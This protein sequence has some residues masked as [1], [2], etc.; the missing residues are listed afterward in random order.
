MCSILHLAS[1]LRGS[2]LLPTAAKIGIP[3]KMT[4]LCGLNE[5]IRTHQRMG[6]D[7]AM[8]G[9][10]ALGGKH[11]AGIVYGGGSQQIDNIPCI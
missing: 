10:P 6:G 2:Q 9:L 4:S 5:P 11:P 3:K 8:A 7:L 1:L